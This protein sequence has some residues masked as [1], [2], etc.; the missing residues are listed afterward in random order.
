MNQQLK[1]IYKELF[2]EKLLNEISV[3]G[4]HKK[5]EAGVTLMD[6]G[7]HIKSIPL[8]ISGAVKIMRV[9]DDGYE[10]LLYFLEK[11]HTCAMTMT[12]CMGFAK[13]EIRAVA[14]M[15]TELVMIPVRKME[16]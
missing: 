5:V 11:G 14:E 9:D 6:V 7:D 16:E 3:N 4:F 12:C 13:S 8:L 2:E 10:L 1:E 15:D